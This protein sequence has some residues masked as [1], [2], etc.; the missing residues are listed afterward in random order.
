MTNFDLGNVAFKGLV[1]DAYELTGTFSFCDGAKGTATLKTSSS[2]KSGAINVLKLDL[3][4]KADTRGTNG[5]SID[6]T[7]LS[8]PGVTFEAIDITFLGRPKPD[9][10]IIVMTNLPL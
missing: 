10:R 9:P 5:V 2:Y 1:S 6:L 4:F 7:K 3:E 8:F